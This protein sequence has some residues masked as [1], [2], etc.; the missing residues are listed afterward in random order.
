[1]PRVVFTPNLQKHLDCPPR[2]VEGG[3]VREVLDAV[4][5][6]QP[7]LAGYVLDDQRRLRK[8]VV[9]FVDNVVV[10]DRLN[11]SDALQPDSEVYVMQALS[12]G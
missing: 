2:E 11:L 5:G 3:T 4:F 8:H 12:G 6:E 1:M 10:S 7:R 9:V